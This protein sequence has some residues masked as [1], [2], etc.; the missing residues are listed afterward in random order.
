MIKSVMFLG[1]SLGGLLLNEAFGVRM[2]MS[3][4][5]VSFFFSQHP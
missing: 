2:W 5:I 1:T 3:F 4:S